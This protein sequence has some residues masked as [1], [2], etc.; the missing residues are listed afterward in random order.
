MLHQE[1]LDPINHPPHYT[2]HPSGVECITITEHYNFN[3]G[4]AI[5][6]LWRAGLK[7]GTDAASDLRKAAWYVQREIER[8]AAEPTA[9]TVYCGKCNA[10][11]TS[12]FCPNQSCP[13]SPLYVLTAVDPDFPPVETQAQ[14][15]AAYA[16]HYS[17][18]TRPDTDAV[19][20]SIYGDHIA[21]H[22]AS[23]QPWGPR[24]DHGDARLN[25]L[26]IHAHMGVGVDHE[27]RHAD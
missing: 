26:L 23:G 27:A 2:Q 18:Q 4:N 22:N 11:L 13:Q 21:A 25:G 12:P 6:Y 7:D 19:T 14:V 1:S 16:D 8:V 20:D 15:A 9:S 17:G 3:V 10:S 5:K 24:H